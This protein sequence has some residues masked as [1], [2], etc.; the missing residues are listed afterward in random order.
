MLC[1]QPCPGDWQCLLDDVSQGLVFLVV[2]HFVLF[3]FFNNS[4]IGNFKCP[5]MNLM[6]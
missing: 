3:G 5:F 6:I 4:I 1:D 2:I